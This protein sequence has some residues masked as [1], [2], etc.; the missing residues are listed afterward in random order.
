METKV[1]VR[2]FKDI[3][4]G[5]SFYSKAVY[6]F[7]EITYAHN[8][9]FVS[10]GVEE[11]IR[12]RRAA[13]RI[14]VDT[15]LYGGDINGNHYH[16]KTSA[17]EFMRTSHE[18]LDRILRNEY[19]EYGTFRG[20]EHRIFQWEI[21]MA[22][23]FDNYNVPIQGLNGS[24]SATA[25]DALRKLNGLL[26]GNIFN[27]MK[28]FAEFAHGSFQYPFKVPTSGNTKVAARKPISEDITA[29]R[30]RVVSAISAICDIRL[31][32]RTEKPLRG[33][34]DFKNIYRSFLRVF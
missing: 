29:L 10:F 1:A 33:L 17:E 23:G 13:P 27:Y 24:T 9:K 21:E 34:G 28:V 11:P 14:I 4:Y 20:R 8:F 26:G 5:Y 16:G 22:V 15:E 31:L 32:F 2:F 25:L 12:D 3:F 7:T 6:I 18:Y 30:Q 19:A